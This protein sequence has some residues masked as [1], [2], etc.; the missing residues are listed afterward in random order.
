MCH[1]SLLKMLLQTTAITF[2]ASGAAYAQPTPANVQDAE[3]KADPAD[4][5]PVQSNPN[6][7]LV[8]GRALDQQLSIAAKRDAKQIVDTITSDQASRLPD[9]N[10]AES[11]GRIPGVT[12]QRD[13]ET[14]D[15][16]FI[17][18][19]GL[20]AALN[21]VQFDGIN[22]ANGNGSSR[23]I[24]L[25]GLAADD[26]AAITVRKSLL[27]QDEGEGIGGSVNITSRTPLERGEDRLS[28]YG[29]GRYAEFADKTGYR[30]GVG[31]TKVFNDSF[32]INFSGSIRR[33]YI[34]NYLV[35]ASGTNI[36]RL[37]AI[38]DAAGNVVTNDFILDNLDEP[39]FSFDNVP[40]GFFVPD[41]VAFE[42]FNY[43][44]QQQV[45]DTLSLS[46]AI[47]WQI[48][49]STRLTLGVRFDREKTAGRE[50]VLSFDN[51]EDEFEEIDGQLVTVFDDAEIGLVGELEDQVE[52]T[53]L[54]YLR[55]KTELDRLTLKYQASYAHALDKEDQ[56]ELEFDTGGN[57]DDGD[58]AF[59]PG[60]F[61]NRYFPV[62]SLS[63]LDDGPY[64]ALLNDL[65]AGLGIDT[66]DV[67]LVNRDVNS[68]YAFKLDADYELEWDA[69]G[70]TFK[71][72]SLGG[73]FERSDV[74]RDFVNF[75]DFSG[76]FF[77]L[78]GTFRPDEDGNA[79]NSVLADYPGLF[80]GAESFAPIG[81]PLS[82]IGFDG[83]PVFNTAAYRNFA[84]NFRETFLASGFSDESEVEV[85]FFEARED[86]YAGY[87]QT[88][89]ESGNF[90]LV[91]GVRVEHY[92]GEFTAPVLDLDARIITVNLQDPND[93][94]SAVARVID[95]G[96][97][98]VSDGF[99]AMSEN[100]EILP[101]LNANYRIGNDI[102]I[103]G[104]IGYSLARPT[105]RQ[106]GAGTSVNIGLRSEN[107]TVGATPVLPGITDAATAIAA[108][109]ITIDQ[110]TEANVFIS[111]GNPLL[112]NARA[113]NLDASFEYYPT[114]G[115]AFSVGL[116]YKRIKNFIFVNQESGSG[117]FEPDLVQSIL[118]AEGQTL[119]DQLGGL[120]SIAASDI[121][122]NI[123]I[124]QPT[125]GDTAEV[126]G[127]EFGF[128][129]QFDWAP[130]FLSH[131]GVDG[132]ITYTKSKAS[133]PVTA[134]LEDDEALV[135]LGFAEEG[136]PL[137]RT[138]SFFNS[139]K[140]SGNATIYYEDDDFELALSGSYQSRAFDATDDFGLD[141]Y[142]ERY[143]QLDLYAEYDLPVKFGDFSIY[144]EVPDI[145][146]GGK[147]ATDAQ[148]IGRTRQLYDEA[149]FN[150]REFRFG[151]RG[152]F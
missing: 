146:D 20:D 118:T 4:E 149:S 36:R 98:G 145:T 13:G 7:I 102:Q 49:D 107:D 85:D 50:A 99:T 56:S 16:D 137:I 42:E 14:G 57:L 51:D 114:K 47:D 128:T 108:G 26:I 112:E 55:G 142:N 18:I 127:L 92:K 32:G 76:D 150:G 130:G 147:K 61:V 69:F 15:G 70:G 6:E 93:V 62:P 87:A 2:I 86:I 100:T 121:V 115:T 22:S 34:H 68:R 143:F 8:I 90:S 84:D 33:R 45:R 117:A 59:V 12:F 75:V 120:S 103:R 74:R 139:P 71:T 151:I 96:P 136:D 17:S 119:I 131:M 111:S 35:D 95:L 141:Q 41:D 21:N 60:T 109:G 64:N 53:T 94:N 124:F 152:R 52:T 54:V 28:F 31:A 80:G 78:D 43:E 101:R 67:S 46:G 25:S 144:F 148:T 83:I 40:E 116:F 135:V 123:T 29:E 39:G 82:A 133:F 11:L 125:N 138:T 97:V 3:E 77:D 129:H 10:I 81:S 72:V 24:S 134:A 91:G 66:I 65:P 30:F 104:G 132:N 5:L 113:L 110:L 88:E 126:Y 63:V 38:R 73:K 23:R 19:R 37:P 105:F 27:P 106:L 9:N 140:V 1:Q 44:L 48:A 79:D 58:L 89:F 122:D